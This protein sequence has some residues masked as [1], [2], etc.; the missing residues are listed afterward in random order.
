M[1]LHRPPPVAPPTFSTTVRTAAG[2]AVTVVVHGEVDDLTVPHLEDA[3][4][5]AWATGPTSLLVDLSAVSFMNAS[6]LAVL[7]RAQAEARTRAVPF[8]V[9]GL[10]RPVTRFLAG[11]QLTLAV[12][13]A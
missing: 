9:H 7:F 12:I 10:P 4:T 3:L 13:L 8:D 11:R 2:S 6:S 1:Q 5:A